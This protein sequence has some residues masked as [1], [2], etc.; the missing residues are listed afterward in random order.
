MY[1]CPLSHHSS[2]IPNMAKILLFF[3]ILILSLICSSSAT[4]YIVGDSSGWDISTDLDTWLVGK[5]FN[6]GD[7]L[8][9]QYSSFHSVSEVTK[10]NFEGCNT[11]NVLDSSKNGNTTLPLTKPGD[12]YFVCGNRLHCLGGM[13]LHVNVDNDIATSAAEAEAGASFPS[14]K[15]NNPSVVPSFA[16]SNHVGLDSLVIVTLGLLSLA[17]ALV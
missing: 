7:V 15:S 10:E 12:R 9:F 14:S 5:R 6:V 3:V 8:L 2:H 17:F 16:L 11:S 1:I 13:K 4:N